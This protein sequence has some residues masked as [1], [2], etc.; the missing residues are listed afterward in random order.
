MQPGVVDLGMMASIDGQTLYHPDFSNTRPADRFQEAF[1]MEP[2][3]SLPKFYS[4]QATPSGD[5]TV[6]ASKE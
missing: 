3:C 2:L 6:E 4:K 5:R 1:R